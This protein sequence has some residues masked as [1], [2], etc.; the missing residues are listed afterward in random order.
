MVIDRRVGPKSAQ[1]TH[2]RACR[3]RS[4]DVGELPARHVYDRQRITVNVGVN[5]ALSTSVLIDYI[6][7]ATEPMDPSANR[8]TPA[9]VTARR[10]IFIAATLGS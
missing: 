7:L 1:L 6:A 9:K 5:A 4:R 3:S 10:E 8:L 2:R